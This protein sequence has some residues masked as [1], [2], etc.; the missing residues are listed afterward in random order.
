MASPNVL[1]LIS[2][3]ESGNKNVMN[4]IGDSTHTAQGYFQL[5][6]TN[7]K[8]LAPG[9][10]VDLS[11]YPNAMSAPYDV[12][13]KV[14]GQL[15]NGPQAGAG[16][17][18]WANFNPSLNSA[19]SANGLPTS[20]RVDP[21]QID[22]SVYTGPNDLTATSAGGYLP[23]GTWVPLGNPDQLAPYSMSGLTTNLSGSDPAYG[24]LYTVAPTSP[25]SQNPSSDP[26]NPYGF[27]NINGS[28]TD[29]SGASVPT[30]SGD[31]FSQVSLTDPATGQSTDAPAS[32]V[33]GS[34]ALGSFAGASKPGTLASDTQEQLTLN[35][36]LS[37]DQNAQDSAIK[38]ASD[39]TAQATTG[40]AQGLSAAFTQ[41]TSNTL[42][43]GKNL[44]SRGTV[45]ILGIVVVGGA[46]YM[47]A[48]ERAAKVAHG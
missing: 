12:Q 16:I 34:T 10:G 27:A 15:L 28:P 3:Y 48:G 24:N 35:K 7:W 13:A 42:A 22:P 6:N 5:T 38:L 45:I 11:Q 18:N 29:V 8:N 20:G 41:A 43:T 46:L 47:L 23:D 26:S 33:G 14:A 1:G 9:L 19:L 44:F 37:V 21:G 36:Q 32:S 39:K 40:A 30:N 4:Y 25:Y 31:P 2:Q 17:Q